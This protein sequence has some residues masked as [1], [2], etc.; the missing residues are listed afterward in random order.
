MSIS[1]VMN[2]YNIIYID[3]SLWDMISE[4]MNTQ[5]PLGEEEMI[6]IALDVS[7]GISY[8]HEHEL[9]HCQLSPTNIAI[10]G[11]GTTWAIANFPATPLSNWEIG[12]TKGNPNYWAPEIYLSNW[13]NQAVQGEINIQ[14]NKYKDFLVQAEDN[15]YTYSN[16]VDIY[17]LGA[18]M[19]EMA[20][21]TFLCVNGHNYSS[22]FLDHPEKFINKTTDLRINN[23]NPLENYS[24]QFRSIMLNCLQ[25]NPNDRM[26]IREVIDKLELIRNR[27]IVPFEG[28]RQ[29]SDVF[30]VKCEFGR[31]IRLEHL[32]TK[33]YI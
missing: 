19:Y 6:K 12:L 30:P 1:L 4:Q 2:T 31:I 32:E 15:L 16:K 23:K 20:T 5:S 28:Y 25:L 29:I 3:G 26:N 11:D 24:F 17:A 21:L 13:L 14:D 7:H 22:E 8:F 33:V 10:K 9:I 18:I 27:I